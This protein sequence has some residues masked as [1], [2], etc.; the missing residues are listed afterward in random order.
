MVETLRLDITSIEDYSPSPTL[1]IDM[2][3]LMRHCNVDDVEQEDLLEIYLRSAIA[4]AERELDQTIV[5]RSHRLVLREFP[6]G[7]GEILLPRGRTQSVES[8]EY[9]KDGVINTLTG[10]SSSPAGADYQE[11]LRSRTG[12]TL[13]PL[14]GE[15]WPSV[16][17][18][19][20]APVVI[21][22]TAG[23][24]DESVPKDIV[25]LLMCAVDDAVELKG[26]PDAI[27]NANLTTGTLLLRD[28]II[29]NMIP[30]RAR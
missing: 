18:D 11:D 5:R 12:G 2:D 20:V 29:K 7:S 10:P 26:T 21:N 22:F 16:D 3:V 6:C 23:Y 14:R 25:H 4:W 8:I 9:S 13:M 1:P 17:C 30:I 24:D 28:L 27:T 19:A 15:S